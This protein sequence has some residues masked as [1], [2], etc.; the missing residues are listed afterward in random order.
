VE[1]IA[2]YVHA[3]I[4]KLPAEQ[5]EEIE[6]ELHGL[7]EDMLE[8]RTGHDSGSADTADI[9]AVLLELGPPSELA[10]KYSGRRRYLI[11]PELFDSYVRVLKIVGMAII[12]AM[13]VVLIIDML[14]PGS[15]PATAF[16]GIVGR[17]IGTIIEAVVQGFVWVTIIFAVLEYKGVKDAAVL[18]SGKKAAWQPSDLPPIPNSELQIKR[19]D[20]IV[21]II[22]T[23]LFSAIL[24]SSPEWIAVHI[25]HSDKY[26]NV[27][28]FNVEILKAYAPL[29]WGSAA[30]IILKEIL[31]LVTG[32][33]SKGLLVFNI[34][35][36]VLVFIAA[37]VIFA[38]GTVLNGQFGLQIQEIVRELADGKDFGFILSIWNLVSGNIIYFIAVFFIFDLA[39]LLYRGYKLRRYL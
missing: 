6:K 10:A 37:L 5:R 9:E 24:I 21:S 30:L 13:S 39:W 38:D 27:P 31:R 23:V 14:Q 26:Y 8:E 2:R 4:S 34:V 29:I 32:K 11:G 18:A 16:N 12:L 19:S 15:N 22:L 36:S 1:L 33:W 7:I 28:L 3:V 25:S 17:W 20:P 35:I